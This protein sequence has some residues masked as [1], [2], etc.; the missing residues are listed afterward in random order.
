MPELPEVETVRRSL[1]ARIVG[2][3]IHALRLGDFPGVLGGERVD[4]VGARVAGREVT[5]IRRRA[6]YLIIDLDDETAIIVH[7]RM[8]G[9]LTL[10]SD[11]DPP[12]RFERLAIELDEGLSLR[13]CDQ[14][15]FGRVTHVQDDALARLDER[16]GREPLEAGFS[17]AWLQERLGRRPGKIKAVLLDQRLIGGLGNIYADESLFLAGIHPER[18]ANTLAPEEIRRLHR[19]IRRILRAAVSGQGTTFSSFEDAEGNPGRYGRSLRV[20]GR[21]GKGACP[22]C[23]APLE[24]IIVGG[25]GTSSC[26]RCQP[27]ESSK[28]PANGGRPS[29]AREEGSGRRP[30]TN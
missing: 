19:A 17:A 3:R 28:P 18:R 23:G 5:G 4:D 2:R 10:A 15:K 20:Y 21:G 7:L 29:P 30:K 27:R 14:R 22:V 11:A 8:T 25:R 6:K 16:L 1:I 13:F 12:L 24:R 26:P 9:K